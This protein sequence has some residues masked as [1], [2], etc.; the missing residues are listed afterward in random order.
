MTTEGARGIIAE[1]YRTL[2]PG[3]VFYPIDLFTGSAKPSS[4]YSQFRAWQDYRW[5]S[6]VWRM[7]YTALDLEGEMRK[8]GFIVNEKGPTARRGT[9]RNVMGTKPA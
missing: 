6:E 3:G 5:N 2:R 4:A 9:D 1:A 8:A 7:E